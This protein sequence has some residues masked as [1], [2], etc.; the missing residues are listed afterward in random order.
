MEEKKRKSVCA[1]CIGRKGFKGKRRK[2]GKQENG[3]EARIS[4]YIGWKRERKVEGGRG[5]GAIEK[6]NLVGKERRMRDG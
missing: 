5:F 3:S 6:R 2:Q 4:Q 1:G